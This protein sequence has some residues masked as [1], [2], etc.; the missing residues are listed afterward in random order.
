MKAT[1]TTFLLFFF[2]MCANLLHA[3]AQTIQVTVTNGSEIRCAANNT[4]NITIT[5]NPSF[6]WTSIMLD[7]GDGTPLVTILPSQTLN[8]TH[9]YPM[10]TLLGQCAYNCSS[11]LYNGA[12]FPLAV[13]G[14]Y[15]N[16]PQENVS[17]TLTFKRPPTADFTVPT[18]ICITD[19]ACVTPV[20]CPSNDYTSTFTWTLGNGM[21]AT[22][23]TPPCMSYTAP[24]T[25]SITMTHGN[26]CDTV[27]HTE[28]LVVKMTPTA[29][30]NPASVLICDEDTAFLTST[31]SQNAASYSWNISPGSNNVEW[32]FVNNT[33]IA[34]PNPIVKFSVPGFYT[35]TLTAINNPCP[36]SQDIVPIQVDA[37]INMSLSQQANVCNTL[38]GYT[39]IVNINTNANASL[40]YS[41]YNGTTFVPFTP[42]TNLSPSTTPKII[43]VTATNA[44]STVSKLDTFYVKP[45]PLAVAAATTTTTICANGIVSFSGSGS[46]NAMSYSWAVS[47]GIAGTNWNFVGGTAFNSMNPQISFTTVNTYTVTLYVNNSPCPIV[48]SNSI[49]VTLLSAPSLTLTPQADVC[50]PFNYTPS[51]N[52]TGATY[53]VTRAPSTNIPAP[54]NNLIAGTYYV[55]AS[56]TNIC[57]NQIRKDTFVVKPVPTAVATAISATTI[58]SNDTVFFSG[59]NSTNAIL[60]S[61]AV[62]P[63]IPNVDWSFVP[64]AGA[65]SP[66]PKIIFSTLNTYTVTL[67]VNNSPCTI[68][69]SNNLTVSM[70]AAPTLVLTPQAD[71]CTPFNYTPTANTTGVTYTVTRAPNTPVNAPYTALIAGTYYVAATLTNLCGT[72]IKRDTFVV[73]PPVVAC[74]QY[75]GNDTVCL[76]TTLTFNGACSQNETTYLWNNNTANNAATFSY[77]FNTL[78]NQTITL[79]ADNSGCPAD[80]ETLT[81]FVLNAPTLTLNTQNDVCA[82]F[83]YTPNP[84]NPAAVYTVTLAPNIPVS[85]PYTNLAAGTY[86]VQA[87]LTNLCGNQIKTDTFVVSAPVTAC[88]QYTGNDTVCLGTTANFNGT[89]SQNETI[90]LWNNNAVNNAATFSYTFN[91]LGNQTITLTADNSGCPADN[92]TLT[93][94]V[95]NA[96]TLTLNTQ[97]D[98][99]AP[100]NYTPSP[101]NPA[102]VYT[103]TLA[104]NTNIPAPYTN[105][106][107]GTYY[108]HASL[109]NLCGNQIKT[110]T[111]VVSTPVTACIQYTG[112]D[113]VCLGTTANFDGT[114]SQ[115]ETTYLWNNN[116]ANNAATF[117]YTFNTLGNQTITLTADNSGCPADIETLNLFVLNAPTLTLNSQSDVCA[118]FN[119]T[120]SP[121]NPAAVYTL[122][123]APNTNIPAPYTNLIAGTYYVQA[124]LTNLCGNQVKTDTFVVSAPVTACIQYTG[125]DTVCLGTTANFDGT[126]SQNETT[127][128]WNNNAA[129]NT[130]TFS[131]TFNTL[132]NQTITLTADNSGCP[133]D[134]ETLTLFVLN[135]PT[136]T[137][138]TQND[139]CAPF[140]YT[141]NPNNPAAVYTVTLAPN[142]NITAPYTNLAAGTYYVHASL[143]N[144][145]GNQIK[146]DTFVVSTPVTACIQ[147]TGNDTVCLGTTANFDG[148]CSQNE[149]TYLWN[150]NAANNAATFSYTFNTLGNQTITLSTDN[151]GCPVDIETLNFFVENSP[152][153][154]FQSQGD[155]CLT[156]NYTPQPQYYPLATYLING[157]QVTN[158]PYNMTQAGSPYFIQASIA[159][160]CASFVYQDTIVVFGPVPVTIVHPAVDTLLCQNANLNFLVQP[161]DGAGNWWLNGSIIPANY[162]FPNTGFYEIIYIRGAGNCET[163]DTVHVEVQEISVFVQDTTV[164]QNGNS[165][166]LSVTA[167]PTGGNGYWYANNCPNCVTSSGILQIPNFPQNLTTLPVTYVYQS[168]QGCKDS[169]TMTVTNTPIHADFSFVDNTPCTYDMIEVNT[170]AAVYSTVSWEID[171]LPSPPPP[172]APLSAGVHSIEM[173]VFV[174]NCIDS[175]TKT[176]VVTPPPSPAIFAPSTDKGCTPLEISISRSDTAQAT[177][178]YSWNFGRDAN[179][180]FVGFLPPNTITYTNATEQII[181]FPITVVATNFCGTVTSDTLITILPKPFAKIGIDSTEIRCSPFAA[182]LI[183]RSTGLPTQAIWDFGDGTPPLAS[184]DSVIFHTYYAPDSLL[185]LTIRLIAIN[186]CG[187]DTA[188][189]NITVIPPYIDSYFEMDNYKVCPYKA[190]SFQDASTPAATTVLWD[191]GDGN[192]SN[193]LNPVHVY[194]YEDTIFKVILY[195]TNQCG[196][197]S[198]VH[199]VEILTAPKPDFSFPPL[200]CQN[201]FTQFTNLSTGNYTY[202]WDFGDGEVDTTQTSPSHLYANGDSTYYV[203]LAATSYPD[204]CVGK[205]TKLIEI[206]PQP[207]ADFELS[208]ARNCYPSAQVFFTN[209]SQFA[210]NYTWYFGDGKTW[211]NAANPNTAHDYTQVGE[212]SVTL[213]ATYHDVCIDSITQY[214]AVIMDF[215]NYNIASAFTPNGDGSNDLFLPI[216]YNA[217]N[218]HYLYILDRWGKIVYQLENVPANNAVGWDGHVNNRAALEGVY[219]YK[220]KME[221]I[222]GRISE[223]KVGTVTLV[224]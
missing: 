2:L 95:L 26:M 74:I 14:L 34:S 45:I 108:V 46:T 91:T 168:P 53:T 160:S 152:V 140:N 72:Q 114:C 199:Y 210:N 48:A 201:Q 112:N 119:Y 65:A 29:V 104:P 169:A 151:V 135:A 3:Q 71:V 121:S 69:A 17:K 32:K 178:S 137:L 217:K 68:V 102:A 219:V 198:M 156:L 177:V 33:G 10:A 179:D 13:V 215:C 209:L 20:F 212:Y 132:G 19:S 84:N 107:A 93:L 117:S 47:P 113:T 11:M 109:T 80:I 175:I 36:S 28:T 27:T 12:C 75:T 92:E 56:L 55:N 24:G 1:I 103:L 139:V 129:N 123:L 7:W 127:Y 206:Y 138:N 22:G 191:F 73:Q 192:T 96:P 38:T 18:P 43:K 172:F 190:I 31:G 90:Y 97:N 224:R 124:S 78:G 204:K 66:T 16:A 161:N 130:A 196:Y 167:T 126:C 83:N 148:T 122:T 61:W 150:N 54:Y 58:C 218:I 99:C 162:T 41:Q 63:G 87:S 88:I 203:T 211:Q 6:T 101:N 77:T 15:S 187:T 220:V 223:E 21:T 208:S 25:Y 116:A 131:Y 153:L 147:Y 144:L 171:N 134:N 163:R 157:S 184:M 42:P 76:G 200:N 85:A 120:P 30:A 213:V 105:L 195:S 49:T 37:P 207:I 89:C 145:C 173:F 64:G 94:F 149:T 216:G 59:T 50:A 193:D 176:I 141:P 4:V 125:N 98:V 100:F 154:T 115:N 67:Y 62:S 44:C 142:T 81:L 128:L 221:Y 79:T 158:F 23:S 183:N 214:N 82:P 70:V 166:P 186:D 133:P 5:P 174:G 197:D 8:R 51:P 9:T 182:T 202:S 86:Y 180:N 188:Y 35:A 185:H 205:K 181:V 143:T 57:G 111:F 52:T 222:D 40:V 146:T 118:P 39:P 189:Q 165:F 170:S 164:C 159:N 136:L 106:A 194:Q 60:Y 155:A 110:D